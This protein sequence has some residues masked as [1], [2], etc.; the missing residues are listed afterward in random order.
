MDPQST[1]E[2]AKLTVAFNEFAR[3]ATEE[4]SRRMIKR[5][6]QPL[7]K[8]QILSITFP[9]R[10]TILEKYKHAYDQ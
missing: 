7:S 4:I 9:D 10:K 6:T 2:H 3:A 1:E 5:D 8:E